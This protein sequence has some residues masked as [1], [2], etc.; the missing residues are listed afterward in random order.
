MKA[1]YI[2]R[3]VEKALVKG[4][5]TKKDFSLINERR[6]AAGFSLSRSNKI[7]YTLIG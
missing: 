2:D 6:A 3:F 4:V 1:V 5:A 7:T